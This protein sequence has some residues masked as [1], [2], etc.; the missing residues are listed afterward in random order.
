MFD[1]ILG[2]VPEKKCEE[3]CEDCDC[4]NNT[5]EVDPSATI[6]DPDLWNL[7]DFIEEEETDKSVGCIKINLLSKEKSVVHYLTLF[8]FKELEEEIRKYLSEKK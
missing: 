7:D 8:Q 5:T 2:P 3:S 4:S 6:E 1:D